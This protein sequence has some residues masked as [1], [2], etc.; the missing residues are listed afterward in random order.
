MLS[1]G[2][3]GVGV[4]TLAVNLAVALAVRGRR[5]VLVD[6]NLY[7]ADV[8]AL[9]GVEERGS[10]ADVLAARREF[11]E[12]LAPGPA[13][14]QVLPGLWAPGTPAEYSEAAQH[15]LLR[16]FRGLGRQADCGRAGRRQ[17][18][19]RRGP[20]VLARRPTTS[21]L[22]TTPDA[23]SVM[24]S[25]AT[26]KRC[27]RRRTAA[28]A[29]L[30]NQAAA[31]A[32]G[33]GRAPADRRPPASGSWASASSFGGATCRRTS[34]RSAAG[35]AVRPAVLANTGQSGRRGPRPAGRAADRGTAQAPPSPSPNDKPRHERRNQKKHSI[36]TGPVGR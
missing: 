2:K 4:T 27:Q 26:L 1:G 8:A 19:Q 32:R 24:D 30:V 25:Y 22:V 10:V 23:V 35:T 21:L 18:R 17:R 36:T 7:R 9:C 12:V 3:G 14:I 34:R 31:A 11:R 6:A 16:Q 29:D 20:P 28:A 13:G 5:V 15:R 33:R